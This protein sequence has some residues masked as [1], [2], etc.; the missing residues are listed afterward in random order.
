MIHR[1]F[2]SCYT[3]RLL[4]GSS[5]S[6]VRLPLEERHNL[7]RSSSTPHASLPVPNRGHPGFKCQPE[8]GE[9]HKSSISMIF[10]ISFHAFTLTALQEL[11]QNSTAERLSEILCDPE[12]LKSVLTINP[13][14]QI[15][16]DQI[17]KA[18]CNENLNATIQLIQDSVYA[19]QAFLSVSVTQI[20]RKYGSQRWRLLYFVGDQWIYFIWC[21]RGVDREFVEQSRWPHGWHWTAQFSGWSG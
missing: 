9:D 4:P 17:Q 18:V 3:L 5:S 2:I 1:V 7:S 13:G 12:Q 11:L 10:L 21:G 15:D 16:M 19:G 20:I 6:S 8:L 14:L